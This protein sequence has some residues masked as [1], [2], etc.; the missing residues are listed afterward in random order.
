MAG[1][2]TLLSVLSRNNN[3][4][5]IAA[6]KYTISDIKCSVQTQPY[7]GVIRNSCSENVQLI[8]RRKPMAKCGFK[9]VALQLYWNRISRVKLLHI[10]RT[11]FPKNTPGRLLLSV[12]VQFCLIFLPCSKYFFRDCGFWLILKSS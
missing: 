11:P 7:R 10:F 9:K 12:S 3:S 1:D 4:F 8:Y 6:K 5:V 2:Q